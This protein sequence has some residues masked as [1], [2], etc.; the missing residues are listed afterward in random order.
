M[1]TEPGRSDAVK[2]VD[3]ELRRIQGLLERLYEVEAG[4]DVTEFVLTD[5]AFVRSLE[6]RAYRPAPEKLLVYEVDNELNVSL[7]LAPEILD[8]LAGAPPHEALMDDNLVDF[9]TVLEGV[10]H[11]VYLGHNAG[12]ERPITRMEMELQAEVDKFVAAALLVARQRSGQVPGRGLHRAL[13]ENPSLDS[14]LNGE[15]QWRYR[16]ASRYA[17]QYC[18]R[19]IERLRNPAD[20]ALHRELRRFYRLPRGHK[21]EFIEAGAA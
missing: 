9:W 2:A 15:E 10:S 8:R 13:F 4:A 5:E 17:G 14:A 21:L 3:G 18:Q 1:S 12:F 7:F 20:G 19:L 6:G 16:T 11:F